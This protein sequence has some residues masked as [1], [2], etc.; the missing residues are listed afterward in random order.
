MGP[1]PSSRGISATLSWDHRPH[2]A[3]SSRRS[4]W[5]ITMISGDGR[6]HSM[7]CSLLSA[8]PSGASIGSGIGCCSS[9]RRK[10][11]ACSP[12]IPTSARA[13]AIPCPCPRR[14]TP[15]APPLSSAGPATV[16]ARARSSHA[17]STLRSETPSGAESPPRN[18]AHRA[19][20]ASAAIRRLRRRRTQCRR[21]PR[22]ASSDC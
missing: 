10:H 3:G 6:D 14:P 13:T 7:A 9:R 21:V 8:R 11:R 15:S 16:L 4:R 2:P 5:I 18:A 1:S 12:R 20:S 17:A 19:M 22:R